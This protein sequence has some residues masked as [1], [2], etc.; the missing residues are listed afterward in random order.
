MGKN[1]ISIRK[2]WTYV[3]LECFVMVS[4]CVYGESAKTATPIAPP[5]KYE[6]KSDI[7]NFKYTEMAYPLQKS[8]I[9]IKTDT[10]IKTPGKRKSPKPL[11]DEE[12]AQQQ[13]DEAISGLKMVAVFVFIFIGVLGLTAM[14]P[15][16]LAF[17][18]LWIRQIYKLSKE[19]KAETEKN[20]EYAK[21]ILFNEN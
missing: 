2:F 13:I 5:Q 8:V 4:L 15:S 12:I 11:T 1:M 20:L 7:L 19:K 14:T 16:L 10:D 3:I 6:V 18:L 17:F 21:K 9:G